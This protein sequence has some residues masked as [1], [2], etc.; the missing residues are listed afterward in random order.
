MKLAQP[1][2]LIFL[3]SVMRMV[4]QG[5]MFLL[6]LDFPVKIR[7]I[8]DKL[9]AKNFFLITESRPNFYCMSPKK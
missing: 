8:S 7:K 5:K 2:S 6:V 4:I 9:T 3:I 1:P